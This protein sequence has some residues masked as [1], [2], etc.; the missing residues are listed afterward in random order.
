MLIQSFYLEVPVVPF[1]IRTGIVHVDIR[2]GRADTLGA[3]RQVIIFP[4]LQLQFGRITKNAVPLL[5]LR[6]A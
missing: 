6:Q 1:V 4:R 2:F 5:L 3:Q